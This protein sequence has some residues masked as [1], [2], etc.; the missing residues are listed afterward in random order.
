V[1]SPGAIRSQV[2]LAS[3]STKPGDTTNRRPREPYFFQIGLDFGTAYTK[4]V[5]RDVRKDAARVYVPENK[6]NPS[7]PFLIPSQFQRDGF[8]VGRLIG[9]D[10]HYSEV[11]ISLLKMALSNVASGQI[12]TPATKSVRGALAAWDVLDSAT[13]R[14]V[15][16]ITA[17]FLAAIL[18]DVRADLRRHF[19]DLGHNSKDYIGVNLAIP[20]A[21]L[22]AEPIRAAFSRALHAAWQHCELAILPMDVR[23]W[24][25]LVSPTL[26]SSLPSEATST[27]FVYPEVSANVQGFVRSRSSKPGMY[28]FCDTG[29][30]TVDQSVFIFSRRDQERLIYLGA[31]VLPMGSATLEH[32]A[33]TART[34]MAAPAAIEEFRKEKETGRCHPVLDRVRSEM[35]RELSCQTLSL[36]AEVKSKKLGGG[37]QLTESELIFGG[38]GHVENP[39]E[40]G[41]VASFRSSIFR[42][43]VTPRSIGLP[44]PP[45]LE[46]PKGVN[47]QS[48]LRRLS[49]AYGLSYPKYEIA[50]YILPEAV[51]PA[52]WVLHRREIPDAP[53]MDEC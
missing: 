11:T 12:D 23:D 22:G 34:N 2:P 21:E 50:P 48:A 49:V 5:I 13:P 8:F 43:D 10:V 16:G 25:A 52:E 17:L 33:A 19:P 38:G 53:S 32:R 15:E 31:R 39:Y 6:Q 30:G 46:L 7:L 24:I 28:L 3:D 41:V 1:Y 51:K 14:W 27:C 35:A 20:V 4:C 26:E 37:R 45:D 42:D 44:R 18:R 40:R 47:E 9:D 29:A 36:L